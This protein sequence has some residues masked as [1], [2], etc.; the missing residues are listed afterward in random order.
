MRTAPDGSA[1][2]ICE[3]CLQAESGGPERRNVNENVE[4]KLKK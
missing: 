2:I 1:E 3:E 4:H